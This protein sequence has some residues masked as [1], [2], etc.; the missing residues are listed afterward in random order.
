M[1]SRSV[2]FAFVFGAMLNALVVRADDD[3]DEDEMDDLEFADTPLLSSLWEATS[4]DN[5]DALDRLLDSSTYAITSRAA[6]GR[7]LAWWA[8]EFGNVHALGSIAALGGDIESKL[9]DLGG[10]TAISMC[11]KKP[12]CNKDEIL[13]KAKG[14]VEDLKAKKAAREKERADLDAS[15]DEDID[16]DEVADDEF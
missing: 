3:E 8:W 14:M 6:D 13:E 2:F 10:E 5:T 12:E 11:D 1:M 9:K 16:D 7:G 4:S 15:A